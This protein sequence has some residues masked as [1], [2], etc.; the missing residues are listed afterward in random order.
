VNPLQKQVESQLD[1]FLRRKPRLGKEVYIAQT[2]IVFGDVTLGDHSSLW[3]H[4]VARGDISPIIVGH[5][6]NIQDNSVL[7]VADDLPCRIGSW[8]TV[9]HSAVVHACT[10]GD[11]CLIGMGAVIL[12]GAVIGEQCLL[13]ARALVPPGTKIPDYSMVLGAPAKV[14]RTLSAEERA[15]LKPWAEKYVHNSAYCL[16]N[17]INV[18]APLL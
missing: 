1:T 13:G 2:A 15:N 18:G 12:D 14:V 17:K 11:G 16:K 5:H 6:T 10:I 8:V 7:H 9:G 3:Y 4:A